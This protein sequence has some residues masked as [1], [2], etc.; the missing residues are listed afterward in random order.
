MVNFKLENGPDTQIS[1]NCSDLEMPCHEAVPAS[2]PS[3]EVLAD[4]QL[5]SSSGEVSAWSEDDFKKYAD[6]VLERAKPL[7][8]TL[9]N[10][11]ANNRVTIIG[12]HHLPEFDRLKGSLADLMPDLAEAGLTRLG[13]NILQKYQAGLRE[14]DFKS[15][16]AE[17]SLD[18]ISGLN[19]TDE[20]KKLILSA[21]KLG[22]EVIFMDSL[23]DADDPISEAR[24]SSIYQAVTEGV[25]DCDN[26]LVYLGEDHI[27][28]ETLMIRTGPIGR[29]RDVTYVR[30]LAMRF[31]E[32]FGADQVHS[33]RTLT[34]W[35]N[36]DELL[37]FLSKTPRV[38][39]VFPNGLSKPLLL[40]DEG[41]I[42]GAPR[43]SSS[44]SVIIF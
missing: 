10:I 12:E 25:R 27:G 21:G 6:F 20:E 1:S 17:E 26:M 40:P 29:S 39:E 5:T 8:E 43:E 11:I 22:V 14:I 34:S 28:K 35:Q 16:G 13:F 37:P 2:R 44:D 42:K 19:L 15:E 33:I 3:V 18:S 30:S 4:P 7:A 31:V 9:P 41:M 24:E 23:G 38:E 36:F 32:D